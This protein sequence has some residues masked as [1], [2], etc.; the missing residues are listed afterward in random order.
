[1]RTT[2][3]VIAALA[4]AQALAG[5]QVTNT[6]NISR[7]SREERAK[8]REVFY[9]YE[10]GHVG[11]PGTKAGAI[12]Y[13][14][15]Q[16]RA[17]EEVIREQMSEINR[18]LNYDMKLIEGSFTFPSPELKG[19]ANLFIVDDPALPSLLAAPENRWVLVNVAGLAAGAGEK[20]QF[21]KARVKKELTRGFCLLAGAQDSGFKMS[22]TGCKTRPEQLDTHAD[23]RLPV[24]V[25]KRFAPYLE[26]YGIRPEK[27]VSY[28]KACEEG[29]AP[30]PTNDVQRAIWK[31]VHTIP[32][33][34]ITIE[35]DPKKDK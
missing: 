23:C 26:G 6:V 16:K 25:V 14:N 33:K 12:V 29:W 27:R 10:G 3:A 18:R 22:L 7:L 19:E 34:P 24:D 35:F 20:P 13:I 15:A 9:Q 31:D 21:F 4:A 32:D 17:A 1:M 8:L 2:I 11:K 5:A 30:P 28:R